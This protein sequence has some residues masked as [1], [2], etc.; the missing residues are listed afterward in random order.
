MFWNEDASCSVELLVKSRML[1]YFWRCSPELD[2][3]SFQNIH[4]IGNC[5][6]A[7]DI[8]LN[9]NNTDA[10]GEDVRKSCEQLIAN[11]WGKPQ[12]K[13]VEQ[14]QAWLR[15]E[16]SSDCHHLL[17]ASRKPSSKAPCT[18]FQN[19]KEFIDTPQTLFKWGRRARCIDLTQ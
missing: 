3:S 17:L 14:Q 7:M 8:L 6:R 13:F 18:F 4:P 19:R 15:N 16:C 2:A 12:R 9:Q 1:A 5:Q 11:H 10:L